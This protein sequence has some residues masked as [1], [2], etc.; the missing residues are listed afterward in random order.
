MGNN[1]PEAKDAPLYVNMRAVD[2]LYIDV[3]TRD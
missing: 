2:I 1:K 3:V